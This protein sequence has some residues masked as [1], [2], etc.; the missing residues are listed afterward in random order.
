MTLIGKIQLVKTFAMPKFIMNRAS[1]ISCDN[2]IIKSIN[3]VLFNFVW[4]GKDKIKRLALIS[5]YEDG[6]LKMPHP[7]S[8]IKTQRITCLKWYLD[9]N[10]RP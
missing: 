4:G 6:D 5:E 2:D 9:D 3:S 1:L 10:S 7:G 8:L